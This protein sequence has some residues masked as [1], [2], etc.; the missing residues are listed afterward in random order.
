MGE[1]LRTRVKRLEQHKEEHPE[2]HVCIIEVYAL[3]VKGEWQ[4]KEVIRLD[5][6][7]EDEELK[8]KVKVSWE[9][10]KD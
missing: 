3:D 2:E 8:N 4:L 10:E 7:D 6:T 5:E 1:K 9:T